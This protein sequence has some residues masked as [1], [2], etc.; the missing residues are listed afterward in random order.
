MDTYGI[1]VSF[2]TNKSTIKFPTESKFSLPFVLPNKTNSASTTDTNLDD[3]YELRHTIL[4]PPN[5]HL[6]YGAYIY[7]VLN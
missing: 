5:I 1:N 3:E 6:G 2:G 7:S 4:M